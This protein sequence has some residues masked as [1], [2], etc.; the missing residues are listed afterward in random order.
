MNSVKL[1]LSSLLL[2]HNFFLPHF[3]S[4]YNSLTLQ[5]RSWDHSIS[6]HKIRSLLAGPIKLSDVFFLKSGQSLLFDLL[7]ADSWL[8][9]LPFKHYF[10]HYSLVIN[11]NLRF[12]V[13]KSKFLLYTS[14]LSF[15]PFFKSFTIL[16]KC[17]LFEVVKCFILNQWSV[18][19]DILLFLRLLSIDLMVFT[20][21]IRN[22]DTWDSWSLMIWRL[23]S[24]KCLE[25]TW[26]FVLN[27]VAIDSLSFFSLSH[28]MVVI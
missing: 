19:V 13:C 17:L 18:I 9:M 11:V 12:I 10:L 15:V 4:N 27:Y 21:R 23:V 26:V 14:L 20:H 5:L 16:F 7:I 1:S 22:W 3:F 24:E 8:D 28:S 25:S 6:P 2:S